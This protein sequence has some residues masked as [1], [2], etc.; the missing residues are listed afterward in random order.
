MCCC[1]HQFDS[2][3][4]GRTKFKSKFNMLQPNYKPTRAST[5]S[6]RAA[7]FHHNKAH[8]MQPTSTLMQPGPPPWCSPTSLQITLPEPTTKP[9]PSSPLT[10]IGRPHSCMSSLSPSLLLHACIHFFMHWPA[11]CH[12]MLPLSPFYYFSPLFIII[13]PPLFTLFILFHFF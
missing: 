1:G 9:T 2:P 8:S 12:R 10:C 3:G 7:L 5:C 4:A 13:H 6:P 11:T